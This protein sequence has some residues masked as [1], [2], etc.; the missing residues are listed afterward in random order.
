[1]NEVR[2]PQRVIEVHWYG[3]WK[4]GDRCAVCGRFAFFYVTTMPPGSNLFT[5][6]AD[7][8]K[9]CGEHAPAEGREYPCRCEVAGCSG[10]EG[11]PRLSARLGRDGVSRCDRHDREA[12]W[13]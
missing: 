12:G 10:E 6:G 7:V 9:L 3:V 1:M 8:T 13:P 4:R 2:G 11:A 5:S